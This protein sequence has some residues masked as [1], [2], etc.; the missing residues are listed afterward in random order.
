MALH[1]IDHLTTTKKAICIALFTL[2]FIHSAASSAMNPV[3]DFGLLPN[4][5]SA[6]ISPD[7][8]HVALIKNDGKQEYLNVINLRSKRSV[9]GLKLD[10]SKARSLLFINNDTV[11]LNAYDTMQVFGYKGKFDLSGSFAYSI[12]NKKVKMLLNQTKGLHPAQSGLG[13]IV[14]FD[15]EKNRLLMPAYE[16]STNGLYHLYTVSLKSGL[17]RKRN[18][19]TPHTVDWF[20]DAKGKALAREDYNNKKQLHRIYSYLD[21]SAKL[22]YE[23]KTPQREVSFDGVSRDEKHLLFIQSAEIY[24]LSLVDGSMDKTSIANSEH[25]IAYF[26]TDINRKLVGVTYNGLLS[27]TELQDPKIADAYLSLDALFENSQVSYQSSTADGKLVVVHVS[28]NDSAGGYFVFDSKKSELVKIGSEYPNIS[29]D[30]IGAIKTV[31]YKARDG[32]KIPSILTWPPTVKTKAQKK[33]LPLIVLPH[34]GPQSHDG[35]VFHWWAQY[36]ASRGY[37]VLQPNFRG[38]TGFGSKHREKGNGEWG[39]AMQDDLSDGVHVL[40]KSGYVD[41]KRVCIV[42]GSYGGYS[43]LAGGAFSPELYR[44]V[45]S[46]AGVSDLPR[47]LGDEKRTYGS[48]HWVIRYWEEIIGD[49]KTEREKLKG[50]SPV[51]FADRFNAPTLLIHGKDDTIVP[52]SQSRIMHKALKK[53]KKE[54]TLIELKGEDHWLSTSSTRLQMLKAIDQFLLKH[55]PA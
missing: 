44:C 55:N 40:V 38:S 52:I 7:G 20:V 26:H 36:F 24:K 35:I 51:N 5:R 39:K 15:T 9:G 13:R 8:E 48:D 30:N 21:G 33:N 17:G 22:V 37:L 4:I 19:G 18:R 14:G 16:K 3:E 53:A 47:M 1:F 28:G 45:I 12:P 49:S 43:A 41:P 32:I 31:S 50:V 23:K 42:G 34:G 46:V 2:F 25:G 6:V 10:K 11:I 29:K 27:F 54:T